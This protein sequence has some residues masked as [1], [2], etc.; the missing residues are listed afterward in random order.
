VKLLT[1]KAGSIPDETKV[2]LLNSAAE[3]F[4]EYGFEKS[5]LRRI[6]AKADVTTGALYFFFQDKEDVFLHVI[7]PAINRIYEALKVHY[8]KEAERPDECITNGE[9]EDFRAG[10][11][12]LSFY[13]QNKMI[14]DII[15]NHEDH[16]A[17]IDFFNNIIEL[18]GQ[19][20]KKLLKS[21]NN[22]LYSSSFSD[23][24]IHWFSHLQ[25]DSILNIIT[26][27]RNEEQAKEELIIMVRFLRG[28]FSALL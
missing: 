26:H 13:Y 8:E 11:E 17:I 7:S 23:Y 16:P 4:A 1:R 18:M 9:D 22:G 14:C 19:Q 27:C 24:T 12:V 6:C 28:G 2:R 3:E 20:T 25:L 5:S 15:L 10:L 21:L